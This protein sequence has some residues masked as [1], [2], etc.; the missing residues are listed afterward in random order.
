MS[1]T[2]ESAL[3]V[4]EYEQDKQQRVAQEILAARVIAARDALF[5]AEKATSPSRRMTRTSTKRA[6]RSSGIA[7]RLSSR[8]R[9]R[10]GAWR[11][12]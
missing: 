5:R 11:F 4:V 8:T 2:K 12:R 1:H 9:T 6:T 10:R 3:L 7:T